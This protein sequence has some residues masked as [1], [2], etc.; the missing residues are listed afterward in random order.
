MPFEVVA[1]EWQICATELHRRGRPA[2]AAVMAGKVSR[3]SEIQANCRSTAI[4]PLAVPARRARFRS[5][6]EMDLWL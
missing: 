1:R 5:V 2:E 4:D 3:M 6:T